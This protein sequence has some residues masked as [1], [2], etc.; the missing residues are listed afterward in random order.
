MLETMK[1][2]LEIVLQD[3]LNQKEAERVEINYLLFLSFNNRLYT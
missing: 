1:Q 2:N 3:F